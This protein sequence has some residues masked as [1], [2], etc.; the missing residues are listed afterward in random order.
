MGDEMH[1]EFCGE[2]PTRIHLP[3]YGPLGCALG[4]GR[5]CRR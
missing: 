2:P 4:Y 3:T 5:R 1:C